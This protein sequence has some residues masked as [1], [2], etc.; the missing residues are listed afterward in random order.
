MFIKKNLDKIYLLCS[1]VI[2]KDKLDVWN[3]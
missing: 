2:H 3:V 1:A